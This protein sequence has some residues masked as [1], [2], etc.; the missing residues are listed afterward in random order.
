MASPATF[1]NTVQYT[2]LRAT[3]TKAQ[4]SKTREFKSTTPTASA[5]VI[6]FRNTFAGYL[7]IN[8]A[9][10]KSS[11]DLYDPSDPKGSK[12]KT[13][14]FVKAVAPQLQP[15]WQAKLAQALRS[16]LLDFYEPKAAKLSSVDI[17]ATDTAAGV[18]NDIDH[19][20]L[21]VKAQADPSSSW[22]GASP[23]A[24]EFMVEQ[25]AGPCKHSAT[26]STNQIVSS[27]SSPNPI[28]SNM[29]P[30]IDY[31]VSLG[32]MET[33]SSSAYDRTL[34]QHPEAPE[35]TSERASSGMTLVLYNHNVAA[36]RSCTASDVSV[37]SSGS[38][39][40][41]ISDKSWIESVRSLEDQIAAVSADKEAKEQE[42]LELHRMLESKDAQLAQMRNNVNLPV[43]YE[44]DLQRYKWLYEQTS[45]KCASL[46]STNDRL[47]HDVNSR[48]KLIQVL[49]HAEVKLR[50]ENAS[51]S[52]NLDTARV[53]LKKLE[54]SS[55]NA[56]DHVSEC[57]KAVEHCHKNEFEARQRQ[58]EAEE[59][60]IQTANLTSQV[61]KLREQLAVEQAAKESAQEEK[62][63]DEQ[64][65]L[66]QLQR[67][68]AA[69]EEEKAKLKADNHL[70][71]SKVS[72]AK[73]LS[74]KVAILDQKNPTLTTKDE[75]RAFTKTTAGGLKKAKAN[76]EA[77]EN[78]LAESKIKV[79][80]LRAER[81]Q[82]QET[83]EACAM[84]M[85]KDGQLITQLNVELHYA[86]REISDA[87]AQ[88]L[89]SLQGLSDKV[90]ECENL[91]K[92]LENESL[93][94]KVL[95]ENVNDLELI[96]ERQQGEIEAKTNNARSPEDE[97]LIQKLQDEKKA[98]HEDNQFN[99]EQIADKEQ[100]IRGLS[101]ENKKKVECFAVG[102]KH[103]QN[104]HHEREILEAQNTTRIVMLQVTDK[105]LTVARN[106]SNSQA[107]HIEQ[108][109]DTITFLQQRN[110]SLNAHITSIT[111]SHD[112]LLIALQLSNDIPAP[113]AALERSKAA[114]H[115][116][117]L[118][119]D[120]L[121]DQIATLTSQLE[122]TPNGNETLLARLHE[123]A[124]ARESLESEF[125]QLY[126][127]KVITMTP[128]HEQQ[129]AAL[130]EVNQAWTRYGAEQEQ[131]V[132]GLREQNAALKERDALVGQERT[133]M[134]FQMAGLR[135]RLEE[136]LQ[137]QTGGVGSGE[138]DAGYVQGS[139]AQTQT[140]A[141]QE[142]QS[143]AGWN[144]RPE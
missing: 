7:N 108:L 19:V 30:E 16:A 112:T 42:I 102:F 2:A 133:G 48:D 70:L 37:N 120:Q 90:E 63:G 83:R 110:V 45:N 8:E 62:T 34:S 95:A 127:A 33:A 67:K 69:S 86:R 39:P 109:S 24:E 76:L 57:D 53:R 13:A 96:V 116:A 139:W 124:S 14:D 87:Q 68:L 121:R 140:L 54:Q 106:E 55:R 107:L 31:Q 128:E 74:D 75:A 73:K 101:A 38:L 115:K 64:N 27:V 22:S 104:L 132:A 135:R 72:R 40:S 50:H 26:S 28:V 29:A 136:L 129:I 89:A 11:P 60:M 113:V 21:S 78:V 130:T 119:Q 92:E 47:V 41:L 143:R 88:H 82:F 52:Q 94:V 125:Q 85:E 117:L 123:E 36:Q 122:Q 81:A 23:N 3:I 93:K 10:F 49:E 9:A 131:V 44:D 91:E 71:K 134:Q 103:Y 35:P 98:L 137:Q 56:Q 32:P 80:Q 105:A 118:K 61:T 59:L 144:M 5:F 66:E 114:T 111:Q 12:K 20:T 18:G 84:Q 79:K 46:S 138:L 77:C 65:E 100:V 141:Q 51:I 58:T 99:A 25:A 17:P 142:Q 126:T 6:A 1:E 43:G 97:D 4:K 15:I